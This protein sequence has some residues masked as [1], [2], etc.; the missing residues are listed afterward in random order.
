MKITKVKLRTKPMKDN[1]E[2]VRLDYYPPIPHPT[3]GKPT[4]FEY[5]GSYY[6][7]LER[8][9]NKEIKALVENLRAQRQLEVQAGQLGF[10]TAKEQQ[11]DLIAF[12]KEVLAK[13]TGTNLQ[14]WQSAFYIT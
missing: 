1:R 10:M 6:T 13:R 2:S 8:T 11:Q 5:T 4:R 14:N 9:H 3:T 12:Y 7:I